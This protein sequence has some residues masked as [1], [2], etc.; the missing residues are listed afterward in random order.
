MVATEQGTGI[1]PLIESNSVAQGLSHAGYVIDEHLPIGPFS[2]MLEYNAATPCSIDPAVNFA[3]NDIIGYVGGFL[4][5]NYYLFRFNTIIHID[6]FI[7]GT[8]GPEYIANEVNVIR[9][10]SKQVS[11]N[12]VLSLTVNG[13]EVGTHTDTSPLTTDYAGMFTDP[14]NASTL[15]DNYKVFNTLDE[16]VVGFIGDSITQGAVVDRPPTVYTGRNLAQGP[17]GIPIRCINE[18]ISGTTTVDWASGSAN[19]MAAMAAFATAGVSIVCVNL[20]VNDAKTAARTSL[21]DY[22][23]NL[24]G[25]IADLTFAGYT[26]V[27]NH[28][29]YVVPGSFGE[30]DAASSAVWLPAYGGIMTALSDGTT[31]IDGDHAGFAYFQA[32]PSALLDGVHP[33]SSVGNPTL[34]GFWS[35]VFV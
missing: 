30:W 7:L 18:G 27:L 23:N 20:G 29:T 26:V 10:Q 25:M 8:P 6:S 3:N 16:I 34:G 35:D 2:A 24:A 5:G 31:I 22:Q 1:L 28:P 32:N 33:N 12:V 19:L 17:T 21:I 13:V 9:L 15:A 4:S 14:T 11:A